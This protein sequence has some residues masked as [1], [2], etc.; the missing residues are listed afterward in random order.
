[1]TKRVVHI[2]SIMTEEELNKLCHVI[3]ESESYPF[4]NRGLFFR[5]RDIT[6]IKL[7]FY[8]GLRPGEMLNL[9]WKDVDFEKNTL[10]VQPYFNKVKIERPVQLSH[11]AKEALLDLY[12]VCKDIGIFFAFIFPSAET[13]EPVT[14]D[15][16]HRIFK[17]YAKEAN[18]LKIDWVD[19]FGRKHYNYTPYSGRRWFGTEVYRRTKSDLAVKF[20][21]RHRQLRSSEPYIQ[22]SE[23]DLTNLTNMVFK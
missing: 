6:M 14:V 10:K 22:P 9:R 20:L 21:M 13:F 16:F 12:A 7:I 11:P 1:M 3:I 8:G 23:E 18:I 2:H 17:R 4:N 19:D 15:W 5:W